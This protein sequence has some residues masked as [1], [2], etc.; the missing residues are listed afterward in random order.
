MMS[1]SASFHVVFW[2]LHGN[3]RAFTLA[4]SLCRSRSADLFIAAEPPTHAPGALGYYWHMLDQVLLRR[5]LV[6]HFE[7]VS[8]LDE[9][10]FVNPR[11]RTPNREVSDHL[12]IELR[13]NAN[14]FDPEDAT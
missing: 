1:M 3:E 12:P 2:N 13:L 14:A 5:S 10:E 6:P 7:A 8:I 11:A 9:D 4:M